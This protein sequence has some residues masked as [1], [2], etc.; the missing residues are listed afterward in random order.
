MR[1]ATLYRDRLHDRERAKDAFHRLYCDFTTSNLRDD[2]LWEE[3]SLWREEG[4]TGT[5]CKRLATLVH[6][7]PDS[8]Y[9]PCAPK[10]CP[11]I[12]RPEKSRAPTTCHAYLER[13]RPGEDQP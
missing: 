11:R 1:I 6:D 12:A 13:P 8:R 9:V 2:A 7:F 5:A 4:D 3:A 10:G